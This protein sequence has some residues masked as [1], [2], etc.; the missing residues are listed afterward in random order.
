[1]SILISI[2]LPKYSLV[3]FSVIIASRHAA[4]F[5][6]SS[7]DF[8]AFLC[9][10]FRCTGNPQPQVW[11]RVTKQRAKQ[12]NNSVPFPSAYQHTPIL[13]LNHLSQSIVLSI[14]QGLTI[15]DF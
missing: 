15:I 14:V 9:P 3:R 7:V 6:V 8:V 13:H 1:M 4:T 12:A 10:V 11:F 5:I 2:I